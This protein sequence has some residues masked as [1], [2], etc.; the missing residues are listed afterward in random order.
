M[1]RV[2][3]VLVLTAADGKLSERCVLAAREGLEASA[4][5]WLEKGQA[6]RCRFLADASITNARLRAE[7]AAR[8]GAEPV[9]VNVLGGNGAL[10]EKRLLASDMDS[11]L[12]EQE[13]IDVLGDILGLGDEM[14]AMTAATMA[15]AVAFEASLIARTALL[16]G[17]AVR[18]IETARARMSLTPGAER[19]VRTMR[20][21]GAHTMLITGGYSVFAEPL[22]AALGIDEVNA[23]VL[24]VEGGRL[25]GRLVGRVHGPV[26][27]RG[28]LEAAASRLGI[29]LS[30]TLAVGDGANDL[31]MLMAAGLGVAFRAKPCVLEWARVADTGAVVQH[32]DLLALLALQGLAPG[33]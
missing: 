18:A 31:D 10:A 3:R 6:Y 15:G 26:A 33:T 23:N 7:I 11:T 2:E 29:C 14:R 8:L 1:T 13:M 5:D 12:I 24:E 27:K 4:G 32:S 21:R 25:T 16:A 17:V 9:D 20:A 28:A 19:L 30:E 22:A